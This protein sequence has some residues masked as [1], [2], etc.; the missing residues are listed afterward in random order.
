M[1]AIKPKEDPLGPDTGQIRRSWL[2]KLPGKSAWATVIELGVT[3]SDAE[4]S[5]GIPGLCS[6]CRNALDAQ[7]RISRYSNVF[8]SEQ[9][10]REFI[11][12]ALASLTLEDCIRLHGRLENLLLDAQATAA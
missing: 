9:C 3:L 12:I 7:N 5:A 11:R 10:E 4:F 1:S 6:R 2:G 8:C